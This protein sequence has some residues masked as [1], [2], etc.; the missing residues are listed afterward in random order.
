[1]FNNCS[2]RFEGA[3]FSSIDAAGSVE[4]VDSV[5]QP[6]AS[7][8]IDD[9]T[10][11]LICFDP[12]KDN[13]QNL[14]NRIKRLMQSPYRSG[15]GENTTGGNERLVIVTNPAVNGNGTFR[16]IISNAE[17]GDYI[18]FDPSNTVYSN[19]CLRNECVVP[20]SVT[21]DG[22]LPTGEFVTLRREDRDS[23]N[24]SLSFRNSNNI[25]TNIFIDHDNQASAVTISNGENY[26]FHQFRIHNPNDDA[27]GIGN[28]REN[29]ESSADRITI[30][31]YQVL[32]GSSKGLLMNVGGASC[33]GDPNLTGSDTALNQRR[34]RVT[35][36]ESELRAGTRNPFNKGGFIEII[37]SYIGG[38]V[39]NS[40]T[41]SGGQTSIQCSYVDSR[42][43]NSRG[44]RA[45]E[46]SYESGAAASAPSFC[47][48]QSEVFLESNIYRQK[49]FQNPTPLPRINVP[50]SEITTSAN[51][52]MTNGI[53]SWNDPQGG[54]PVFS[55]DNL[56]PTEGFCSSTV[57]IDSINAG[58]SFSLE[59]VCQ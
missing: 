58:P 10:G 4:A 50:G 57:S 5:D 37:H 48:E 30:S 38:R 19:G 43:V 54:R 46:G 17:P 6:E 15:F 49:N 39:E 47:P 42:T 53:E 21:I 56:Q 11:P 26:W 41:R 3:Q 28:P 40:I 22:S 52:F 44:I 27:L 12:W 31:Q 7:E 55:R 59:S 29:V 1:L 35:V 24:A 45:D 16:D 14:E 25:L 36:I 18:I 34:A 33:N 2:Q 20:G 8:N 32:P 9:E 13:G 51:S 23:F